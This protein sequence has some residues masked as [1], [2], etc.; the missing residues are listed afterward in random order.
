MNIF[1]IFL[2][3]GFSNLSRIYRLFFPSSLR[4]HLTK[5]TGLH[6]THL[7]QL[8]NGRE[9][10]AK[11]FIALWPSKCKL[12]YILNHFTVCDSFDSFISSS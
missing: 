4:T 12:N 2:L 8:R 7:L 6:S 10:I 3:L 1:R 11:P 5:V 9:K